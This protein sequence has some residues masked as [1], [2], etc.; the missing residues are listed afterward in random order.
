MTKISVDIK[1]ESSKV[2][3]LTS[4]GVSIIFNNFKTVLTNTPFTISSGVNTGI[5]DVKADAAFW[6]K[7]SKYPQVKT[8]ISYSSLIKSIRPAGYKFGR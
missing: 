7:T 1:T 5:Y 4:S 8:N 2:S 3:N 6:N